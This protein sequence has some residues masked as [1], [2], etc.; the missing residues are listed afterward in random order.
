MISAGFGLVSSADAGDSGS[1]IPFCRGTKN[2]YHP[3]MA[4]PPKKPFVAP[5]DYLRLERVAQE[6]SEYSAGE[7]FAMAG[8]SPRHSLIC[9]N[10]SGELRSLLKGSK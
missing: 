10:A 2:D 8:G 9:A 7:I 6:K 5:E 1:V 3:A 4:V